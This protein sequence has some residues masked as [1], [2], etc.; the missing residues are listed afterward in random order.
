MT[1]DGMVAPSQYPNLRSWTLP[2]ETVVAG[3][4]N[5]F[6]RHVACY[7]DTTH[8]TPP[9]VSRYVVEASGYSATFP[10]LAGFIV[11]PI[12]DGAGPDGAGSD[13]AGS[14]TSKSSDS[15]TGQFAL[16]GAACH[17]VF[18]ALTRTTVDSLRSWAEGHVFRNEPST[19]PMRLVTFRQ[20]EIVVIG[21]RDTVQ[22]EIDGALARCKQMLAGW[23]LV[24]DTLI[25][26]DSFAGRLGP[27]RSQLQL[28]AGTK[29]ELVFDMWQHFDGAPATA[30]SSANIHETRFGTIFTISNSAGATA[31]SGCV[32]LGLER[33]AM[34]LPCASG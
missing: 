12:S 27:L 25:A 10:H 26:S 32:G 1:A 21:D 3:I 18:A 14:D 33:T 15:R 9:V 31:H 17:A 22:T 16:P 19:D 23:G 5:A 34:A 29:R 13:G 2:F 20:T 8:R 6:G 24:T 30:L 28:E 7:Y 11:P 4:S